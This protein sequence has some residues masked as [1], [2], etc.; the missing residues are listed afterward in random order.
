MADFFDEL[1]KL[2]TSEWQKA[3]DLYVEEAIRITGSAI[4]YFAL[5]SWDETELTM[6]SWSKTAMDAC[7]AIT[8]PIKYKLV[9][10]GLWG[11]C[12]RER[13]YVIT[14]DYANS[15]SPSKKGYPSGH[16][17]VI[18]HLNVPVEHGDKI[19]GVLGVGNKAALYSESDAQRLQ[20]FANDGWMRMQKIL[21]L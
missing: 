16:V 12:V 2:E 4:G 5:M 13:H 11:D 21:A 17:P 14:N 7:E 6:F 20:D 1:E 18:R 8:K 10:T 9:E 19:R 3:V 15:R